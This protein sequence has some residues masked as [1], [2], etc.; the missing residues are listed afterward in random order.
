MNDPAPGGLARPALDGF[1]A[2][3]PLRRWVLR[4]VRGLV[5]AGVIVAYA[6]LVFGWA[7]KAGDGSARGVWSMLAFASL[8]VQTFAFHGGLVLLVVWVV[9]AALRMKWAVLVLVPA[10]VWTLGAG[11]WSWVRPLPEAPAPGQAVLTVMSANVLYR[12]RDALDLIEQV[13][14][15]DP[16]VVVVQEF[17][18]RNHAALEA[19]LR[20]RFAYAEVWSQDDAFGQAV[21]SRL[22]FASGPT[23]RR[24]GGSYHVPVIECEVE[25]AGRRVAVW[26]VH[27]LPPSGRN[28]IGKQREMAVALGERVREELER[29]DG[30][31]AVVLAGDFNAPFGTN[32]LREL[33]AAGLRDAHQSAG[34]GRGGTWPETGPPMGW[35]P[36]IALDHVLFSDGLRCVGARVGR[37]FGSDHRP[38]VARLAWVRERGASASGE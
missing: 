28:L 6:L 37:A 8:V 33:R 34:R 26:D 30:A 11:V 15:A 25:F 7:W 12:N 23:V 22:A 31:D 9:A 17:S 36:K 14:E 21:F 13:D 1:A 20:E 38:V 3:R 19:A 27:T 4:R 29:A 35:A 18:S 32:H 5:W 24:G 10:L 2:T 16:D